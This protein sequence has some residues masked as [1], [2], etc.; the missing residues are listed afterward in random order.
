MHNFWLCDELHNT[1]YVYY[2][3]D[4]LGTLKIQIFTVHTIITIKEM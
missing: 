2:T 4:I 3:Y 1:T